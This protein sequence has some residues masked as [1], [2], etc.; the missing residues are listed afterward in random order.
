MSVKNKAIE[1][2][3]KDIKENEYTGFSIKTCYD[4]INY[5]KYIEAEKI[6]FLLKG[7]KDE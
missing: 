1:E 7:D 3:K 6:L 5:G 2:L 4:F